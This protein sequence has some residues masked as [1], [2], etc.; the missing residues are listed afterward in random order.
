MRIVHV[1]IQTSRFEE[2][3][4]FYQKAAGLSIQR[5]MRP[6]GTRLV[7]LAGAAGD[8]CVEVIDVPEADAAR[9]PYLSIGFAVEDAEAK[10][11]E[12]AAL[13]LDPTPIISPNPAV[14]FFYVKDPAGVRVQFVWQR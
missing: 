5:D 2:E 9:D 3:I 14:K 11:I 7:F 13:G 6:L 1:T 12:L 10:R 8:T 4:A